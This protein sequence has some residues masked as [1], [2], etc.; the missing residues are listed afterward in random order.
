MPAPKFFP[1]VG[2]HQNHPAAIGNEQRASAREFSVLQPTFDIEQSINAGVSS[3]F[4][5]FRRNPLGIQVGGG[6]L[7]RSEVN[8]S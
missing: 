5:P 2:G 8:G 3:N 7:G 4:D 6:L 1:P